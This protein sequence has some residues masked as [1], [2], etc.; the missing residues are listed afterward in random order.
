MSLVS[1]NIHDFNIILDSITDGVF[2]VSKEWRIM[3]FNR[4]AEEITGIQRAEAIGQYCSD[5]F[6]ANICETAC[7][8]RHTMQTGNPIVGKTIYI[9][10]AK[11][12][13]VPVSVS[14]ALLKDEKGNIIGGVETFRDLSVV[15]QLRKEL[16]DNYSFADILS[17][18]SQ[19]ER[20]FSILPQIAESDSAVLIEGESGTGK[21]LVARAIHQLSRRKHKKLV[22]VNCSALPDTLLESELFGYKAGA[23]T[24]ARRDKKGRFAQAEG[25]T[26]FLDEIGDISTAMQISLLRALQEKT[27]QPLGSVQPEKADVRVICATNKKLSDLV[28]S[29]QFRQDLYYRVNVIRIVIPPLRD[30]KEDI[31]LLVHH[32]IA[33][34]NRI[35]ARDVADIVPEVMRILMN[36][37]YPGN[38]RELENIIERAVVLC[39]KNIV[40]IEDLPEELVRKYA[41]DTPALSMQPNLRAM[42]ATFIY[43]ILEKNNWNRLAAA[44]E[45]GVHKT[46]LFRKIKS[47]GIKLPDKDGR[48]TKS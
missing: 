12:E 9:V 43:N 41:S 15:Q 34:M 24:D 40:E 2:T 5:V 33:K 18:N 47:L 27:Y 36:H 20:L 37:N 16:Q 30:R 48:S 31:P 7:V 29:G 14:T 45:I 21:E 1:K 13:Q 35:K 26:I 44:R 10:D 22:C 23:F 4:A 17:K 19:M 28:A 42:E 32:F 25:G 8:L 3:S 46:T 39:K 38:V 6:R 11:G